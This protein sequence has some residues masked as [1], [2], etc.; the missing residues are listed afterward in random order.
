MALQDRGAAAF[1]SGG[2]M[3]DFFEP[4][5][6]MVGPEGAQEVGERGTE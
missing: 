2:Q 5:E 1:V 4:V 3:K 6:A